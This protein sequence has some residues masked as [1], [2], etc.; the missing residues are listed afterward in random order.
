MINEIINDKWDNMC[1][2]RHTLIT[3]YLVASNNKSNN[4]KVMVM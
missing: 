4:I 2:A 3:Q 1:N